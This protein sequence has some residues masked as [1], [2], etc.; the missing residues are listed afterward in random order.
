VRLKE[1]RFL[2][3]LIFSLIT[4]FPRKSKT[5]M[6]SGAFKSRKQAK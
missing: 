1:Y 4:P 5:V 6:F 3:K 2:R